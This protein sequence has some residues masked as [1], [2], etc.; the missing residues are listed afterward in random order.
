[1]IKFTSC[2]PMVGGS[3]RVLLLLP[4]LKLVTMIYWNIAESGVKHNKS[5]LIDFFSKPIECIIYWTCILDNSRAKKVVKSAF[6][7]PWPCGINFKW[8]SYRAHKL[9]RVNQMQDIHVLYGCTDIQ[10]D[11]H[12]IKIYN[13]IKH[14]RTKNI[15]LHTSGWSWWSCPGRNSGSP[16]RSGS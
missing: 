1:V 2:L 10:T 9:L 8:C 6:N 14:L 13:C 7:G 3:L 5:N 16:P 11:R 15:Y 4:P 12:G